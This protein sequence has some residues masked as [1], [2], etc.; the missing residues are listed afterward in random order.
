MKVGANPVTVDLAHEDRFS[1]AGLEVR[2]ATREVIAGGRSQ[3]LEPR[4]MQVL[5]V[6]ARHRGMVVSR[7]DLISTCWGGRAVGEDAI[8]RCI[9]AIRRLSET[10]GGFAVDTVARV[11]YRLTE[12]VAGE[13]PDAPFKP[14]IAVMPFANLTGDAGQDYFV[15]GMVVEITG[16]LSRVRSI[17]VI[18]SGSSLSFKGKTIVAQDVARQ[19]GVRYVLEGSIRRSADRIRIT[20]QLVDAIDGAQVWSNRFDDVVDDVFAL[21]DRV[22]VAVAGVI[23]PRV[24]HAEMLRATRRA[25]EHMSGYDLYLRALALYRAASRE[26]VLEALGL[27][28]QAIGLDADYGLALALAAIC[29]RDIALSGWS[30]D[31]AANRRAAIELAERALRAAGDDAEVLAFA[32]AVL[33]SLNGDVGAVIALFDRA[34]DLN[35]GSSTAWLSSGMMRLRAGDPDTAADHLATSMRLD[36]MSPLRGRQLFGLGAARFE[37]ER[38]S[39]AVTLLTESAALLPLPGAL[40][41]LVASCALNGQLDEAVQGL[42]R[43]QAAH[44]ADIR[45]E[46]AG[47]LNARQRDLGARGL[48]L[49]EAETA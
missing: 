32:G 48:A 37:Q 45:G 18:G 43:Y 38:W 24:Q 34:L 26:P 33:G 28:N 11:G 44:G 36:P 47:C 30:T 4:I 12:V 6:L 35:P 41:L 14:S 9:G 15:D 29:H 27:L 19:L 8:N 25:T 3:V 23:E 7:D 39:D 16:A 49:A 1:L 20:V 40:L 22:A 42:R 2:P 17:L 10:L 5:V 46:L 21:Q 31:P 13:E